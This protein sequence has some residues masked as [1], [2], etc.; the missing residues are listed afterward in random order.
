M[1]ATAHPWSSMIRSHL[2]QTFSPP[3]LD[4]VE[5]CTVKMRKQLVPVRDE[6]R[7]VRKDEEDVTHDGFLSR[8]QCKTSRYGDGQPQNENV[9]A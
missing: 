1:Q 7:E 6:V 3:E 9:V 4:V 5:F 2:Q 8:I